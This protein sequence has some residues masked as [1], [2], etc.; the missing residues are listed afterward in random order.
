MKNKKT[1][2][3]KSKKKLRYSKKW[4]PTSKKVGAKKPKILKTVAE[5]ED[6]QDFLKEITRTPNGLRTYKPKRPVSPYAH[7]LH[8]TEWMGLMTLKLY[9]HPYSKNSAQGQKYRFD[10][11]GEV[12]ENLCNCSRKFGLKEAQLNWVACEEFG[13]SGVA[14]LHVLFS[15]D[16]LKSKK[17]EDKI[18]KFNFSEEKGDFYRETLESVS[19]CWRKLNKNHSSVD[20]HWKPMWE[21]EGL[22]NY[23]CK[24][25][26]GMDEKDFIFSKYWKIHGS[27]KA[28]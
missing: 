27:L 8:E 2:K 20:F 13:F 12:M 21:N 7:T 4:I 9:A 14:H 3:P 6:E 1:S 10:F 19:F 15:F 22:V 16:Y 11:L 26:N 25:E 18:P 17:R 23:F 5:C 24:L 28:A